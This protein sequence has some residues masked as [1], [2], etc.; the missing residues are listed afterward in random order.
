MLSGLDGVAPVVPVQ[1]VWLLAKCL[2]ATQMISW[3]SDRPTLGSVKMSDL[4]ISSQVS[5]QNYFSNWKFPNLKV[6][7]GGLTLMLLYQW[8]IMKTHLV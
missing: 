1:H 4:V 7:M 3:F 5:C 8:K 6:E 2:N